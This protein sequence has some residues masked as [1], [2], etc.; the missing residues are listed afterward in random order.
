MAKNLR[1]ITLWQ[2]TA[3]KQESRFRPQTQWETGLKIRETNKHVSLD[4]HK[5]RIFFPKGDNFVFF[6]VLRHQQ[7]SNG[8]YLSPV[9]AVSPLP[10]SVPALVP[11]KL[12]RADGVDRILCSPQV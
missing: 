12:N 2:G 11:G 4:H 5:I 1:S 8:G 9:P 7:N 6:K 10:P 3:G